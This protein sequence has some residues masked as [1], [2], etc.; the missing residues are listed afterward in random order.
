[1]ETGYRIQRSTDATNWTTIANPGS[2]VTSYTDAGA[3][4]LT[5]YYYRV[6]GTTAASLSMDA[7]P[8]YT[9][10]PSATALPAPWAAVDIGTKF[11]GGG[12][13]ASGYAGGT[14]TLIAGGSDIFGT[15]DSFRYT[16]QP[17]V[18]NGDIIARVASIE[19][20]ND[21]AKVAV[22]IRASLSAG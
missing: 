4:P 12:T 8:V 22:I 20:T 19:N 5:E 17:L 2:D 6:Y 7:S 15:A 9:A 11:G 1:N 10:T 3:S 13:G 21:A 18:G 16:Y 14:F